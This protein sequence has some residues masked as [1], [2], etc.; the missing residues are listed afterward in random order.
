MGSINLKKESINLIKEVDSNV[1]TSDGQRPGSGRSCVDSP[2]F[3]KSLLEYEGNSLDDDEREIQ[4]LFS[5]GSPA[6]NN[7][8]K[9]SADLKGSNLAFGSSV[10]KKISPI[11][12]EMEGKIE[13]IVPS[14]FKYS[15]CGQNLFSSVSGIGGANVAVE[16]T[17][18]VEKVV[19]AL[20]AGQD[21]RPLSA[22]DCPDFWSNPTKNFICIL[23]LFQKLISNA[24]S[25][26]FLEPVDVEEYHSLVKNPLSFRDIVTALCADDETCVAFIV[27][28]VRVN[29]KKGVLG[30]ASLKRWNMFEGR[31]LIEAVDLVFLNY[32][33]FVGKSEALVRKDVLKL[34]SSFWGEI[35][36]CALG[37]RKN[38]P[39]KRKESSGFVIRRK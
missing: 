21:I 26:S 4:V 28:G 39:M 32:L 22:Q 2:A 18:S 1:S 14:K 7:A 33:A 27:D 13:G 3:F 23:R 37:D 31:Q 5:K 6:K 29:R 8:D 30:C 20:E 10:H 11:K 19:D 25:R 15:T 12:T 34:R 24:A 17:G 38:I 35:R 36:R 9:F 16:L